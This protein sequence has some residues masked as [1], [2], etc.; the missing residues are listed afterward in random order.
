MIDATI[1][2]KRRHMPMMPRNQL[3]T[4]GMIKRGQPQWGVTPS[5]WYSLSIRSSSWASSRSPGNYTVRI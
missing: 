1:P 3:V 2:Y 4:P 5:C